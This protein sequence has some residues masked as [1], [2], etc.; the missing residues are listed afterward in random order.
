MGSAS[1]G[2]CGTEA[3]G[4]RSFSRVSG[5]IRQG[6]TT[7][8]L[9]KS[10]KT[11]DFI[12]VEILNWRIATASGIEGS[13]TNQLTIFQYLNKTGIYGHCP[14]TRG[15]NRGRIKDMVI[16]ALNKVGGQKSLAEQAI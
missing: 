14:H 7:P 15:G 9:G 13:E 1:K 8:P 2:L 12:V 16:W 10:K 6:K 5:I 4:P 3:W 11:A